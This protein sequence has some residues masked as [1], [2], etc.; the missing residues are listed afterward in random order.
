M[1]RRLALVLRSF[2]AACTLTA[3]ATASND[4][5]KWVRNVDIQGEKNVSE[6]ALKAGLFTEEKSAWPFAQVP[7]YDPY[8]LDQDKTRILRTLA[9]YGF[10]DAKVTRVDA[11]EDPVSVS[12][13]IHIEEGERRR[14]TKAT[15]STT[16][17]TRRKSRAWRRR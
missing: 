10:F 17:L 9:R 16:V 11:R 1:H 15:P 3:C 8:E 4:G 13:T 5:R 2:F 14:S 7:L 6:A 12:V